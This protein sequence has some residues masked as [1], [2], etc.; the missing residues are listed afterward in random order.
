MR[1]QKYL[2]GKAFKEVP[3][4]VIQKDDDRPKSNKRWK[5]AIHTVIR[6]QQK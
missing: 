4:R 6:Q 3:D 1:Y 5:N 2:L